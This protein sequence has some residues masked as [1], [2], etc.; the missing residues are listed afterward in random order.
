VQIDRL[1]WLW[2]QQNPDKRNHEFFGALGSENP[3]ESEGTATLEDKI[4]ML[5][6]AEDVSVHDVLTTNSEMLCYKYSMEY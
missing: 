6:L 1:W 4:L 2:Q 5:G 3:D